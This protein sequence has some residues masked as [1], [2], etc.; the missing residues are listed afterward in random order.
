MLCFFFLRG[1]ETRK[2]REKNEKMKNENMI[3]IEAHHK[4]EVTK[5]SHSICA[6]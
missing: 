6:Q 1:K 3:G 4:S 5:L 2:K